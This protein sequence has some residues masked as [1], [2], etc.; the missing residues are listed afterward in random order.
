ME[1]I[2]LGGNRG[3]AVHQR[4]VIL[5]RHRCAQLPVRWLS[6]EQRRR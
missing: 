3:A 2:I 1:G 4:W 5:C 6:F